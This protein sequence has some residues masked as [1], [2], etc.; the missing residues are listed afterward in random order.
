VWHPKQD[1]D[2][3]ELEK[4]GQEWIIVYALVQSRMVT[5][6]LQEREVLLRGT[7]DVYLVGQE[8]CCFYKTL[9]FI[10][11]LAKSLPLDH[12]NYFY[13]KKRIIHNKIKFF[14]L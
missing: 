8:I 14:L 13:N 10:A 1:N 11:V 9:K 2:S 6:A 12:I 5:D 7:A 3:A 4:S